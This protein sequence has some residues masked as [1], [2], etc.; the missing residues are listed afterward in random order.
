MKIFQI[1]RFIERRP[2]GPGRFPRIIDAIY[3]ITKIFLTILYEI[4]FNTKF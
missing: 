1:S 4:F 3:F 2:V